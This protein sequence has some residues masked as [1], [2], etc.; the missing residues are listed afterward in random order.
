L[1]VGVLVDTLLVRS[2]VVLR[3]Y[4]VAGFA[5]LVAQHVLAHARGPEEDRVNVPV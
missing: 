4:D 1:G 2:I 3:T 5:D